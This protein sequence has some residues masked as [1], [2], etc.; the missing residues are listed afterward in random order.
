MLN[1]NNYTSSGNKLI[2]VN[3]IQSSSTQSYL[4]SNVT[5]NL[6]QPLNS[7][8]KQTPTTTSIINNMNMNNQINQSPSEVYQYKQINQK[9]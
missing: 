1:F 8:T 5:N 3:N 6:Y 7:N 4:P 9:A 2:T